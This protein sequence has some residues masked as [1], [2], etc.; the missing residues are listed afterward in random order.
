M[1]TLKPLFLF[2]FFLSFTALFF[3]SCSDKDDTPGNDRS[4]ITYKLIGSSD[5]NITTIVY[6]DGSSSPITKT[7]DFGSAWTS[8]EITADDLRI[9][10][11]ANGTGTSDA[12]TLKAQIIKN[13]EVVKENNVSTGKILQTTLSLR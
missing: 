10:I 12:S 6:Y 1:K 4:T 13:G 5:V 11:S 7:G 2:A 8:E 3:G 9:I